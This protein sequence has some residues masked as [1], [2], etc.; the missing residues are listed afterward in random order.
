MSADLTHATNLAH[1]LYDELVKQ[2]LWDGLQVFCQFSKA[3]DIQTL[4]AKIRDLEKIIR[5][6]NIFSVQHYQAIKRF[7]KLD[8]IHRCQ[9]SDCSL[10]REKFNKMIALIEK[11]EKGNADHEASNNY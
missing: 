7:E 3:D 4:K 10:Q 2:N 11:H 8:S 9:C 5:S 1:E 6:L